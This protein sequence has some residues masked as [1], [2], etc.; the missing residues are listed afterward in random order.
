[1][2]MFADFIN[3]SGE[4]QTAWAARLGVSKS[5]L[6]DLLGGKR[7][8]SLDLAFRIERATG[9]AVPAAVWVQTAPA[10]SGQPMSDPPIS[11]KAEDAA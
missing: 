3:Q 11:P 6:S 7:R 5:Y 2:P 1:M 9:G 4:T 10:P 8:P